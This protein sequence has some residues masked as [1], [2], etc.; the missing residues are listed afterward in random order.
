MAHHCTLSSV[1]M[2]ADD[3]GEPNDKDQFEPAGNLAGM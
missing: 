3:D 1:D 2:D